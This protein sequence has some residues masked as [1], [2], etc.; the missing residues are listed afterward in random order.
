MWVGRYLWT[1]GCPDLVALWRDHDDHLEGLAFAER[2]AANLLLRLPGSILTGVKDHLVPAVEPRVE[3][4]GDVAGLGLSAEQVDKEPAD[5]PETLRHR[6][7]RWL[8][9]WLNVRIQTVKAGPDVKTWGLCKKYFFN[10]GAKDKEAYAECWLCLL[11]ACKC[12]FGN[13]DTTILKRERTNDESGA[14]ICNDAKKPAPPR[15]RLHKVFPRFARKIK[16]C[17]SE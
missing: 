5:K 3:V 4:E 13:A 10:K 14:F 17:P 6:V 2:H 7:L 8:M 1:C 15:E 9:R 16:K 11:M 12:T